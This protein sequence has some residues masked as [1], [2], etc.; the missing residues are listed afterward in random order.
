MPGGYFSEETLSGASH[1]TDSLPLVLALVIVA[2]SCVG[3]IAWRLR[4]HAARR[5]DAELRAAA[6]YEELVRLGRELRRRRAEDG[7]GGAD[8]RAGSGADAR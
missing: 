5:A 4:R 6:A 8:A 3:L 2:S 7:D 1:V